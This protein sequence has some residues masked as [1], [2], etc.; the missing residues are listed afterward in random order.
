MRNKIK[1]SS[2]FHKEEWSIY[3]AEYVVGCDATLEKLIFCVIPHFYAHI[4][5]TNSFYLT[6]TQNSLSFYSGWCQAL[7]VSLPRNYQLD[8]CSI[9]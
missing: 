4:E 2:H 1:R 8:S 9:R 3:L 6:L 7:P 5:P